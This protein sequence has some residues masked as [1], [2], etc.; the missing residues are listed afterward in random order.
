MHT[1]LDSLA[2]LVIQHSRKIVIIMG[3]ITVL[4]VL[5]VP[6]LELNDDFIR[7][8]D[9]RIEF[10]TD[11]EFVI[12]NLNGIYLVE[13]SIGSGE[14]QGINEPWYL[15]NLAEFTAWLREQP[16]VRHVFSYSDIIKRLNKNMHG[17]DSDY[18]RIPDQRLM[19][20][21]LLFLYEN[22]LPSGNDLNDR[23]N[24]DRSATRVTVAIDD[25]TSKEGIAFFERS[26][27]WLRDNTPEPMWTKPTSVSV[28][29]SYISKRNVESMLSG[30]ALAIII[31]AVV[32]MLA[33]RSVSL[34]AL[35][36]IPNAVPILAMYGLWALLVGQVGIAAATVTATSLGIVVD[37]TVHFLSKYLRARREQQLDRPAAIR[38]AF[39]TVGVAI[40]VTT[41]ILAIGFSVLTLSS[42]LINAQMG[43]LTSIAIILALILDFLLLPA[44]LL[45]GHRSKEEITDD[46]DY[47]S[48]AA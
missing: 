26:E 48:K 5:Q 40:T 44:L 46:M 6:R 35:S 29:F 38:Y 19:A 2:L 32:M 30:N 21:Q 33:L 14:T 24:I 11:T 7:Y 31:I 12:D 28:M 1:A 16:E 20:A 17:D 39:Q 37:D 22:S 8:F 41:V 43:L 10:R 34:G 25:M 27:Q 42:F 36:L 18:Y 45:L 23:I 9:T 3:G 15:N 47:V 13:Y 4:L